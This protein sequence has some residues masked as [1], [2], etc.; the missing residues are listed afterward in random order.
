MTKKVVR[1]TLTKGANMPEQLQIMICIPEAVVLFPY[2]GLLE[3]SQAS[4]RP[5][6][7]KRESEMTKVAK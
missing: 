2:R 5:T 7:T 4:G 6:T 1:E 3:G